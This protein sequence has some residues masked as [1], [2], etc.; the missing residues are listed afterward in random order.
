MAK[1]CWP[2]HTQRVI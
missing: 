2:I 1:L